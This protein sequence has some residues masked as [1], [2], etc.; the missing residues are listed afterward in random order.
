MTAIRRILPGLC[1][2]PLLVTEMKQIT[3]TREFFAVFVFCCLLYFQIYLGSRIVKKY[4][5][6][7]YLNF[8]LFPIVVFLLWG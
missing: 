3:V 5:L 4:R 1:G 6:I 8:L 2:K 7:D